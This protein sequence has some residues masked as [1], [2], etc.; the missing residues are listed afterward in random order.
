[1]LIM[2]MG[3][4]CVSELRPSIC[5]LSILREIYD[6]EEQRWNDIDRK[7]PKNS[8]KNQSKCQF[9]YHTNP[10]W[11]DSGANPGLGGERPATNDLSHGTTIAIS[12]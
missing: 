10:T 4:D 5:L 9:V 7:N 12:Q 2:S 6:V 3:W 1:M 11:T 8:E